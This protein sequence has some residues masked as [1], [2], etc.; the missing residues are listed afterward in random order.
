MLEEYNEKLYAK[1]RLVTLKKQNMVF[2]TTIIGVS[3][4]G[5]LITQDALERRFNFDEV[6]FKGIV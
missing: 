3:D 1:D 2:Q 4:A 5:Q 6:E